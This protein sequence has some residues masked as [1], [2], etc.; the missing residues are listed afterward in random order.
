MST[1]DRRIIGFDQE[2]T[3]IMK[4]IARDL[5]KIRVATEASY[6]AQTGFIPQP[7]ETDTDV[8]ATDVER[9]TATTEKVKGIIRGYYFSDLGVEKV[10]AALHD[11]G[12]VFV[13]RSS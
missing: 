11:A 3:R 13:D 8:D 10:L 6:V 4:G 1:G 2:A 12:I 7:S 5:G 9:S